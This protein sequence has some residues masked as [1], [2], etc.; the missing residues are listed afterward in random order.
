MSTVKQDFLLGQ[1]Y[2][3]FAP[4]VT[5]SSRMYLENQVTRDP[6]RF[7]R[8]DFS[9]W[10]PILPYH[11][12]GISVCN[13]MIGYDTYRNDGWHFWC[14]GPVFAP[15]Q[16]FD[17]AWKT[18]LVSDTPDRNMML[19]QAITSCYAKM[20][21][22]SVG[23]GE[24]YFT[25][26]QTFDM[27]GSRA[28][29]I[30]RSL[31][32]FR[33]KYPGEWS[34]VRRWIERGRRAFNRVPD[35]WLEL[36]YGWVP[37]LSDVRD[38]YNLLRKYD[39]T[40]NTVRLQFTGYVEVEENLN[41]SVSVGANPGVT[42]VSG[43]FRKTYVSYV[44]LHYVIDNV[45]AVKFA[46]TDLANPV[47]L[48]WNLV[49]YSFVVDWFLPISQYVQSWTADWGL[50]Y[51]GGSNSSVVKGRGWV[52]DAHVT[53]RDYT[54]PYVAVSG[55]PSLGWSF[56]RSVYT[57]PPRPAVPKLRNPLSSAHFANGLSL[58]VSAFQRK[59]L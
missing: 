48:A 12:T 19:N 27:F 30:G 53:D 9:G 18:L 1:Q 59:Y 22:G 43:T 26:Q 24:D 7:S 17:G 38:G 32:D 51:L 35:S 49:P 52:T 13:P 8:R 45:E 36:Q 6:T 10:R 39:E 44:S 54:K 15:G 41:S 42:L 21:N 37:L 58:L 40:G 47:L 56:V 46:H 16:G 14:G 33:R 28:S 4:Y 23:L 34:K 2:P 20:S 29:T 50:R 55:P 3:G 31:R 5:V 11:S 57:T 25:R